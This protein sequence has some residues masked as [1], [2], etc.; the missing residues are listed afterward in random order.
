V[1]AGNGFGGRHD[2]DESKKEGAREAFRR[3]SLKATERGRRG[4]RLCRRHT[5][6]GSGKQKN[7]SGE[8]RPPMREKGVADIIFKTVRPK[9]RGREINGQALGKKEKGKGERK[10]CP[11]EETPPAQRKKEGRQQRNDAR[12]DKPRNTSRKQKIRT[13]HLI[14]RPEGQQEILK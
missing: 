7:H 8:H 3:A 14:N 4:D 13:G 12:P 11:P 5:Q 2:T 6:K 1:A 9:E 10:T